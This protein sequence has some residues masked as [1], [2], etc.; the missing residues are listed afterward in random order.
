MGGFVVEFKSKIS[1]RRQHHT[2]RKGKNFTI[3]G[4]IFNRLSVTM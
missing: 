3:I 4:G 1:R 2:F